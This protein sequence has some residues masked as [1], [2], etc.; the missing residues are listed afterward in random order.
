MFWKNEKKR[1]HSL[2]GNV[3]DKKNALATFVIL[4][5]SSPESGKDRVE[6]KIVSKKSNGLSH[7]YATSK[8]IT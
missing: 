3:M 8:R 6:K 4:I 5:L 7:G 1:F 2:D